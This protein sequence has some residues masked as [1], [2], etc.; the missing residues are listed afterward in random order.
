MKGALGEHN[1]KFMN[2]SSIA[3]FLP[4]RAPG[5]V[6]RAALDGVRLNRPDQVGYRL[7]TRAGV[8]HAENNVPAM[9]LTAND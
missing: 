8:V 1:G 3:Q 5:C 2:A 9:R 7:S 6:R 4:R